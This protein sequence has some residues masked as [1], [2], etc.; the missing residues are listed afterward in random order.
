MAKSLKK[1][2][3]SERHLPSEVLFMV[4]VLLPTKLLLQMRSVCKEWRDVISDCGFIKAH[5]DRANDI[6]NNSLKRYINNNADWMR[7]FF[8][9]DPGTMHQL[10]VP[11]KD[12]LPRV[13]ILAS[14]NGLLLLG[15]DFNCYYL[16]NPSTRLLKPFNGPS[17]YRDELRNFAL[18]YDATTKAYKVVRIVRFT[19]GRFLGYQKN[20]LHPRFNDDD[21]TTASVYN[22]KTAKWVELEHFPYVVCGNAQG[23]TVNGAPHWVMYREHSPNDQVIYP[24][25]VCFDLVEDRF[26]EILKPDWLDDSSKFEYGV[27]EGKLCFVRYIAEQKLEVWMMQEYGE[28]WFNVSSLVDLASFPLPGCCDQ[29][30]GYFGTMAFNEALYVES[31]VSPFGGDDNSDMIG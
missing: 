20:V 11:M 6:H 14:C 29:P 9:E 24:V 10:T 30:L 27:F 22:I 31:L 19:G 13:E 17:V 1:S 23:V 8:L 15:D 28:S 5:L 21:S 2:S 3:D 25:I 16:W 18:G 12:F 4:L 26:K 7:S